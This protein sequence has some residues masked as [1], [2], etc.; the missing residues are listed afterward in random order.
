[1]TN[2][3]TPKN[4]KKYICDSCD[5]ICSNKKD[6]TRHL[7]TAKHK[8]RIITNEN[9]I[10]TPQIDFACECGK[11]YKHAG[12]LW[13]HKR[14][15]AY[16]LASDSES[17]SEK[18]KPNEEELG[19]KE[20][21]VKMIEQNSELQ[22]TI[23]D[24]QQTIKEMIPKMGN[25]NNSNNTTNNQF[26]VQLFL[27]E[28]CK[29]ALNLTEFLRSL[30]IG[31]DDLMKIGDQGY[32]EGISRILVNGLKNLSVTERPIHCTDTKRDVLYV[33]DDNI[34]EKEQ[35]GNPK[36]QKSIKYLANK[37]QYIMQTEWAK[38]HPHWEEDDTN[39]NR[40]YHK[41]AFNMLGGKDDDE[42]LNKRITKQVLPEVKL[43]K[44]V[45]KDI[46]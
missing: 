42:T 37:N 9:T 35:Q 22:Q 32:S 13:N 16:L 15:C 6:Y 31:M 41:L 38:E 43:D 1:M 29:D 18:E 4:P 10:K 17:E 36:F 44:H 30:Q 7:N 5:F 28:K 23:L 24:Q 3:K 21:L 2:D 40:A 20:L 46:M 45:A 39:D 19:Y 33:K 25:N 12:S 8:I 34:W 26:N 27:N 14:K 11:K